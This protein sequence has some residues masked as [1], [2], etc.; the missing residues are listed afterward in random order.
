M[1][2]NSIKTPLLSFPLLQ[3]SS[4]ADICPFLW[5]PCYVAKL[6]AGF[7]KPF[8]AKYYLPLSLGLVILIITWISQ[9]LFQRT[10]G[11]ISICS[12]TSQ[13]ILSIMVLNELC[14]SMVM[15]EIFIL[16]SKL[17]LNSGRNTGIVLIFFY[18]SA[19]IGI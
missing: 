7:L 18:Y 5:I 10:P 15:V 8:M 11:F 16:A 19:P 9:E 4:M 17:H 1:S 13:I 3:S 6:S 14:S 12:T 2:A